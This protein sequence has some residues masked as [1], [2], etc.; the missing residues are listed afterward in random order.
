MTSLRDL[1][2]GQHGNL[3]LG[4]ALGSVNPVPSLGG[5]GFVLNIAVKIG[6]YMYY[7]L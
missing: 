4:S 5:L 2:L 3:S 6:K 1:C 7:V